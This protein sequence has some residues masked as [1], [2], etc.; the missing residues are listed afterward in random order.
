MIYFPKELFWPGMKWE[1]F[2]IDAGPN[3]TFRTEGRN[4]Q[5]LDEE[6]N[7]VEVYPPLGGYTEDD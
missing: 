2:Y 3:E 6:H 4:I 1:S 7:M 5:P